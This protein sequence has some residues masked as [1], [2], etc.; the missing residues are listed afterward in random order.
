MVNYVKRSCDTLEKL[1]YQNPYLKEFTAEIIDVIKKDGKYHI[2]LDKSY[3]YPNTYEENCDTGWIENTP[4]SFIYEEN[5]K[6]YHVLDVKPLK[7]HRVSCV[8]D[9]HR[10]FIFMQQHLAKHILSACFLEL[11]NANTIDSPS[12]VPFIE[13]DKIILES[14]L[15]KVEEM[16]NNLVFDNIKVQVLY[17]SNPELKKMNIKKNNTN[18]ND[19]LRVVQILSFKACPC[20]ALH[21]VSTIEIQM[22]KITH[23][24]KCGNNSRIE[25]ICGEAAVS[26]YLTKYMAIEKMSKLFGCKDT[27]V[28]EKVQGLNG[29]LKKALAEK[30]SL[31]LE[32]ADY[33]VQNMLAA[34]ENMKG[35]RVIKTIYIDDPIKYITILATKLVSFKNVIVL[36]GSK[37]VGKTHLIFMCS[38]DLNL[39]SMNLLLKDAITLIDGKGGG[40][41]FSAQGSGKGV[42]NLGSSLDYAYNKVM[43]LLI[44][45]VD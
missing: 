35:V 5:S 37:S 15:V 43:G 13:I 34:A 10:K 22:I 21:P 14:D 12:D 45:F 44:N 6:I 7:I 17:P 36:F 19:E 42:N 32:I 27:E 1:Y 31:K 33:E 30:G 8:I 16:S 29:E 25:F 20:K 18:K 38:K 39:I 40:S 9:F 11:L 26:D 2:Q 24:L 41:D 4:V 3:F 23:L 28:L